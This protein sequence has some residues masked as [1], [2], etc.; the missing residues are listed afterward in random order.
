VF[1]QSLARNFQ[2]YTGQEAL[3]IGDKNISWNNFGQ[4]VPRIAKG[5]NAIG[6]KPGDRVAVLAAN[7]PEHLQI[8]YAISWAGCVLVPLNTRLSPA[9]LAWIILDSESSV[10]ISDKRNLKLANSTISQINTEIITIQMEEGAFGQ[11]TITEITPTISDP[12][13]QASN[14]DLAALYYTGGTT[15]QPKGVMISNQS[16]VIQTLNIIQDLNIKTETNVLHAPPLFHLAGAGV[17]H[18]CTFAGA[19]QTF[20]PD[21]GPQ[22]YLAEIQRVQAT[23][24]SLVPTMI[25]EI[26]EEN[27]VDLFLKSVK[28]LVYGAAPI[29]EGLLKKVLS[30][31]PNINLIQIYGQTECTGPCLIL[32]PERHTLSGPLAGKLGTAGRANMT[33]EV[34][35]N[36]QDGTEAK[37]GTPGE[38]LIRGPSIML[39]YWKQSSLTSDT[40]KEGWLHTGDIGVMDSDGYVTVVDRMKDMIVTGGENV[41]SA[42][43][44]NILASYPDINYC[45]V[46]G[47]PDKKWGERVHAIIG[48]N[49]GV[50]INLESIRSFCKKQ[51]AGYK[52]PRSIDC[53]TDPLPLSGVGKVRKDLLRE[54]F[55][56]GK[57]KEC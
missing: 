5:L 23:F 4:L 26:F 1:A 47:V 18:A 34:R 14:N 8:I 13:W 54:K 9:E 53:I 51:I 27:D 33:S 37:R 10:L 25:S 30:K 12:A 6:C 7:T 28:T 32:P 16:L 22:T 44:E 17:A 56:K 31:C 21:F 46:I 55:G 39:G 29:T 42:E 40:L 43:V 35:I 48:V 20:F 3:T 19:T 38:I 15:G 24:I 50:D 52:C 36:Q 2:T 11:S 41:F 49:K 45:A 57:F